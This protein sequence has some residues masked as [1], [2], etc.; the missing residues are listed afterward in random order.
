MT[1]VENQP[2][3]SDEEARQRT[4]SQMID[5]FVN[6]E[7]EKRRSAGK[8]AGPFELFGFQVIWTGGGGS[9]PQVRLSSEVRLIARMEGRLP[10][11]AKVGD[12]FQPDEA[13]TVDAIHL[14]DDE[15]GRFA[16]FSALRVAARW[17]YTFDFRYQQEAARRHLAA[18]EEFWAAAD[19][20]F[21]AKH[22]RAFIDNAYSAAELV[23]KIDLLLLS[24]IGEGRL[25]HQHVHGATKKFFHLA[26]L[27]ALVQRLYALRLGA[28]Y[29][30]SE[31]NPDAEE[32]IEM[33]DALRE[34]MEHAR[35]RAI[36]M[37]APT[38]GGVS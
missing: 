19:G 27:H 2:D 36:R 3:P 21:G 6:P 11:G 17:Y 28:R 10:Q 38:L 1:D 31:F 7:I 29:L 26:P 23:T 9:P 15:A 14:M 25:S 32:V 22:T 4:L 13:T 18:A 20:A 37:N 12:P 8:V 24:Q 35:T 34:W 33:H 5:L 30:V 16:H